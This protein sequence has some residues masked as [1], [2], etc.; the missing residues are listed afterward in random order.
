M[1]IEKISEDILLAELPSAKSKMT[2]DLGTVSEIV[3]DQCTYDV[4]IDFFKVELITSSNISTLLVLCN[5]LQN[6][7]RKLVLC[8]V[9][10]VTKGIFVMAGLRNI[11]TFA[12]NKEAAFA[13]LR[14]SK[15]PASEC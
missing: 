2:E 7:G 12:N 9:K 15:L 4:I 11:F 8:N 13:T 1:S 14:D 6:A 3:N 10:V 5:M